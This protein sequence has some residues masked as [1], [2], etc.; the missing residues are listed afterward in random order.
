MI[1]VVGMSQSGIKRM[2]ALE[3]LFY[4]IYGAIFGGVIGTALTYILF[5]IVMNI[6]EFQ[7]TM[8]WRNII[9]A[10]TGAT[11]VAIL[12][13][14]YPLKRINDKIIVESIKGEN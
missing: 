5:N 6:R 1:K 8:P 13:G 2:V 7:W 4:G 3:S 12:S 9:M 11:V 10:C 14:A